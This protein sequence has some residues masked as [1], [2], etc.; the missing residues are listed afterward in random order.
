MEVETNNNNNVIF[1]PQ[2][3][4]LD[5]DEFNKNSNN[6]NNQSINASSM[7]TYSKIVC[8]ICGVVM[9]A[10]NEGICEACAKKNIDITTGITKVASLIYCRTCE[11]YKR[12]PWI[13]VERESQDMMNLCL[14]KI[15]GLNKVQLIDSSFVWTEPHSKEIK[16]KLT[17]QKELNKSLIST[18]FIVTFKE[19]WTQCEDCKKTF[20][21]HIWRAV[22]QLRQ[23]V[24]H[25]RTFLFLEQVILKHKAQNKA[26]NIKEHPEGVDFYF[27]NRSQA[28]TFCSFIHEFLPCQMKTSR[29]LI[30]VDEKSN[31]AEYKETF[32]LE[33][34][35]I[36]QDDLVILNED[37]YKKLGSIGP[38]LLCY[39]QIKSLKF[40]DPITF[41][42]LDL[43]NNTYWRYELKSEIDRKCLSEFLIL[44]V[45]EEIDYKKLAEKDKSQRV[46]KKIVNN[47]KNKVQK[48]E[49][50]E[51]K[52][53]IKSNLTNNSKYMELLEKKLEDKK[54]K[55]VNVKCIRNSEKEENK[56]IIEIRSFLGRK[57]R[58]GD[59]YYGYDLTRI[60]ISDENEE[61]LSKKKGK[62]PDIILVKKKY[63]NYRRIFK[64]KHLKMDVDGEDNEQSEDEEEQ[65][66]NNENNEKKKG[67]KKFKK[68]H[69]NKNKNKA[70]NLE[71]DRDEFLKDVGTN[72][73]IREYI[74]LYK[75]PKALDELNKQMDNLGIEQKDLNDSDLDIKYEELLDDVNENLNKL[76]LENKN[77]KN[78]KE[79]KSDE[80]DADKIGKRERDGKPINDD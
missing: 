4:K 39:K 18:S 58:P 76:S 28:N 65:E 6:I 50:D 52:N 15:K 25:K 13:K 1:E 59:V 19:D 51:S 63:N 70:K 32:R 29:Q 56:E 31:E 37:N 74:N 35:P 68:K 78:L 30:S 36:C 46:I 42:T 17:I 23:K 21:P 40:I 10:N 12:P 44:N 24:N 11:R 71:K 75:D 72:K 79:I 53:S 61:F 33:I 66:K 73:D 7:I 69:N 14:S 62:I 27:S 49:L 54:I 43:D 57:M 77:D 48:M 20:T 5:K 8:C 26:L 22:V 55:I 2:Y 80:K 16:L 41:E 45:E 3:I 47:R 9:D 64:L 60:N 67:K 34:A 38:V